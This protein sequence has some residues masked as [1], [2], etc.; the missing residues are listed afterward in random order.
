M[1][2][3]FYPK[4]AVVNIKKNSKFYFPYLLTCVL[5]SGMFYIMCM[6]AVSEGINSMM[7]AEAV[8]FILMFGTIVIGIFSVIFLF[9][10]NSF[11]MKR[12][13]KE[14]GLYNIL[15]MEK[16]HI[17]MI[18]FYETLITGAG[19]VAVGLIT[20]ILFSKLIFLLLYKM[21]QFKVPLSFYISGLHA[22]CFSAYSF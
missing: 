13:K 18:L 21:I 12:R 1:N 3:L 7:G 16:R 10:T 19:T 8:S 2:S 9:Y 15:G 17:S 20:G 14:I 11:L 4:L 5:T 6:I 22:C